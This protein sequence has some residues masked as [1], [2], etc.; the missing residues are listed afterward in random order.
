MALGAGK[1][2]ALKRVLEGEDALLDAPAKILRTC[3]EKTVWLVD[4]AAAA[5]LS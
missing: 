4:E 5:E 1:A 2:A 3:A